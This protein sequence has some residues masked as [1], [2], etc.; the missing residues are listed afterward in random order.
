MNSESVTSSALAGVY[1]VAAEKTGLPMTHRISVNCSHVEIRH[2]KTI[3]RF[4]L[5]VLAIASLTLSGA[6]SG[7]GLP[8]V[9]QIAIEL[10][11]PLPGGLAAGGR[12]SP[13]GLKVPGL[14]DVPMPAAA[15]KK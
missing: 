6:P 5:Q 14:V 1:E 13:T 15:P 2:T 9:S 11:K 4:A 7:G 10:Y 12:F 3:S 8:P